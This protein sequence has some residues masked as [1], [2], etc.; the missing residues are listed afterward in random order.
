MRR[1]I[2]CAALLLL[3][4]GVSVEAA[5]KWTQ[6]QSENF[7]FIGDASEGQIRRVAERLE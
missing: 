7:L 5:P 2:R 3:A 4:L 6:L 1:L